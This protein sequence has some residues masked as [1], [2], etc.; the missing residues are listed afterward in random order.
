MDKIDLSEVCQNYRARV[1]RVTPLDDYYLLETNRGPKE[2]HV[3]PRVDVMRWSFAWRERLA[4]QGFREVERF[5]RTRESKPYVLVGKQGVTMTD[6]LRKVDSYPSTVYTSYQCGRVVAMMHQSQQESNLLAGIDYL[7]QEQMKAETEWT[8]AKAL[9]ESFRSKYRREKGEKRWVAG[10]MDPLLQRMERSTIML[11]SD[12]IAADSVGVS[13]RDLF[14]DNWGLV[15]GKLHLRGFFRPALS[16]QQR[17][18]ASYLRDVYLRNQ[19]LQQVDSFLDGYE[20]VKPLS[21]GDYTLLLAFMA[22]PREIW[23]SV[24]SYVKRVAVNED[25]PITGIEQA[26]LSQQSIDTLLR[27]IAD[28]AERPRSEG[29]HE[30]L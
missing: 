10:L 29:I 2:L 30:P 21:Y 17:D 5:I 18:V 4:R 25:V 14:R 22:R 20:E 8:R 27:H 15:S 1:I 6:H 23:K 7:Q 24:E 11:G 9:V 28:R 26:L 19:D 3:W 16:V 13:H 12:S